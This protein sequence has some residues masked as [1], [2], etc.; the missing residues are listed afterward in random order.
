VGRPQ[1]VVVGAGF[2]GITLVRELKRA[3]VDVLLLDRNNFHLFTPLLYQVASALLDPGEIARPVRAL[4][5]PLR[6]VEFR[7]ADVR[8][9]DLD[10]RTLTTD[11]GPLRYDYLV[12]AAGSV[13]N[14][15]GN[16]ELE[17][18]SIG[19]KELSDGLALRN[20]V[21]EHFE[22][23][24]W[25]PDPERRRRLLT[26]V[27]VGGGPTGV[28]Y[29][30]ALGEL[31]RLVLDRDFRGL[32][33]DEIRV[34]LVEGS[35]Q[36]LGPF[37]PDLQKS[38]ENALRK[39]GIEV[40]YGAMVKAIHGSTVELQDGRTLDAG[41]VVWTAGVKA[42]EL[43][44]NVGVK[45]ARSGRL[46]VEPTL[47]LPG[48]PEVFVIGDLAYLEQD[49]KPLPQLIPVAM[50]E[51]KQ[52]GRSIK[53]RVEGREPTPFRYDDPGIM[54]TIGRN[55]GVAQIGRVHVSGFL[56]WLFWLGVHL[57]NVVTFR[58]KLI[59]LL[60]WAWEYL[61]RDR[62]VRLI[63]RAGADPASKERAAPEP[64]RP[65]LPAARAAP[66]PRPAHQTEAAPRERR[67]RPET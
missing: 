4:T 3:P 46:A 10:A 62:P 5:R 52:A 8:S 17:Q 39:R 38:A 21:L 48:H 41:T 59:V 28:E 66:A 1:V 31:I 2:A 65:S 27:I 43:A 54:A 37:A 6:N 29:A 9:V 24:R 55:A 63:V 67:P 45:T 58:S 19:L 35:N 30:G 25:E 47:Q 60:N 40:L 36:L 12:L 22:A 23:A 15:F 14:Y 13:T 49:G 7:M 51:A 64:G 44:A 26:F 16:G 53:A 33:H 42:S 50:Q 57:V 61:L 34:V 20:H 56:G 32:D 18:A 11:H